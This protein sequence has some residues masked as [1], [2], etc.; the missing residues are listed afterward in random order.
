MLLRSSSWWCDSPVFGA[1]GGPARALRVGLQATRWSPPPA[2]VRG[3]IIV[4][5][6]RR[7]GREPRLFVSLA[8]KPVVRAG[9]TTD[10][11][12][13]SMQTRHDALRRRTA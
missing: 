6:R 12:N 7:H 10:R 4:C 11:R 13:H 1:R 5:G 9:R 3:P 2:G 8:N